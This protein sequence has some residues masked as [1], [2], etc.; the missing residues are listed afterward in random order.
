MVRIFVS[1]LK[2]E[3]FSLAK[4]SN[5]VGAKTLLKSMAFVPSGFI[6]SVLRVCPILS[7]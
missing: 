6:V 2:E 7:E 1:L 4:T 5:N 3:W